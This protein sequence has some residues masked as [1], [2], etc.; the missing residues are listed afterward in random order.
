MHG[1]A[2]Y[3]RTSLVAVGAEVGAVLILLVVTV[4]VI[5]GA[6]AVAAVITKANVYFGTMLAFQYCL[7]FEQL[8]QIGIIITSI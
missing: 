8:H 3:V 4:P 5:V 6:A 1:L 2:C 7:L